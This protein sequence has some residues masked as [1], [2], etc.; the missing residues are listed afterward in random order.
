MITI[1]GYGLGNVSAFANIYKNHNTPVVV[2]RTSAELENASKIIL[3][4]VGAFDWAMERLSQS[5]MLSTLND[6]V[7]MKKIPV[8]GVCVG[9]QMMAKSSEEGKRDGL[10]WL[11][12]RVARLHEKADDSHRLPH[13][14]WNTVNT[15]AG[16]DL[17]FN[18]LTNPAEF[19]FLHSF[20]VA[21]EDNNIT[22]ATSEHGENFACAVEFENIYGTQFHPEKSHSAGEQLLMNFAKP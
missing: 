10:G 2:A 4:G 11:N 6:L 16:N 14:G 9:M 17:L 18:G 20:V 19:Y 22:S 15:V 7:M 8:L 3:P 21:P 5:G 1:V 12:A 13:M